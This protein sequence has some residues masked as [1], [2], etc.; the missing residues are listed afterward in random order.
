MLG[1]HICMIINWS[2]KLSENWLS[3]ENMF[4]FY[5]PTIYVHIEDTS[6]SLSDTP[7]AS[8]GAKSR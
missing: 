7:T 2:G 8:G 6:P 1:A 3:P 5:L 4:S